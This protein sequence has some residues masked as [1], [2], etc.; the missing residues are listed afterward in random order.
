MF[1]SLPV[2][3]RERRSRRIIA[4]TLLAIFAAPLG[5][6][7]Y[8][9]YHHERVAIEATA[10]QVKAMTAQMRPDQLRQYLAEKYGTLVSLA[11]PRLSGVK[12]TV[13]GSDGK[14][15]L[16]AEHPHFNQRSFSV[17][18]LAPS[19]R[20]WTAKNRDEL[21]RAGIV[22]VRVGP[23]AFDAVAQAQTKNR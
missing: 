7:V 16:H 3:A 20:Q 8:S 23:H 6:W 1:G 11:L 21:R 22:K 5:V 18:P 4:L 9:H 14:Y 17:S 15:S 2:T 13:D 10:S 19:L 12:A